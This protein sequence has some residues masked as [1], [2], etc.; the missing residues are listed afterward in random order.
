LE[1][2][3][4]IYI[5]MGNNASYEK[6]E[7][8][9]YGNISNFMK[10]HEPYHV[11]N[12]YDIIRALVEGHKCA[13]YSELI[14]DVDHYKFDDNDN[15][16]TK[17]TIIS[18]TKRYINFD[19]YIGAAHINGNIDVCSTTRIPFIGFLHPI[20][21]KNLGFLS[22]NIYFSEPVT[23]EVEYT[24]FTEFDYSRNFIVTYGNLSFAVTHEM[25]RCKNRQLERLK[26]TRAKNVIRRQLPAMLRHLYRPDGPMLQKFVKAD[27]GQ[28]L[29][30]DS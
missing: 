22:C 30:F 12:Y 5:I 21:M 1:I 20:P 9:D 18:D 6:C 26:Q 14:T 16:I 24:Y 19:I 2:D 8:Y 4:T 15:Y 3:L 10:E 7:Y 23:F 11:M 25:W 27:Y 29:N 17:I 28:Q 13:S